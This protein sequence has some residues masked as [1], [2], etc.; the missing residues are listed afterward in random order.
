MMMGIGMSLYSH[1]EIVIAIDDAFTD[2]T[3]RI[4]EELLQNP[5]V[6]SNLAFY[7]KVA[8]LREFL[9]N[10]QREQVRRVNKPPISGVKKRPDLEYFGGLIV[11]EVESSENT[12]EIGRK[13]LRDY[14]NEFYKDVALY[15]IVTTGLYWEIYESARG[16]LRRIAVLKGDE[17]EYR[18]SLRSVIKSKPI[19]DYLYNLIKG[20]LLKSEAYRLPPLPNNIR[21]I[22][23]PVMSYVNDLIEL[24]HKYNVL[25][26]ALYQ[27]YK[28]ILLRAYG[29]LTD[30]EIDKL[31]ATHTLLQMIVNVIVAAA[32]G[33]LE[34]TIVKPIR[35]CSNEELEYDIAIPHLMWWREVSYIDKDFESR[36]EEIC[37]DIYYRALLFDWSSPIVEDVFSHLYED[38]VERTLRYKIG[39]Y[40]TPWWLIEFIIHHMKMRFNISFKDK[41]VFDPACGSG[42]FLV[43]AFYEKILEGED[44]DKA[45]L[46]VIGLDIL[47]LAATIARA[48]LIIAYRRATG[49][50]P[51][52]SPLVF[53]GD[54][55][56]HEI[57]LE[58]E[59]V[60]ELSSILNRLAIITW[61]ETW[62]NK[63]DKH[64]TWLF[65]ARLEYRMEQI[66]RELIE[67]G[68]EVSKTIASI[69]NKRV[70]RSADPI[71]SLVNSL[72][73]K[74]LRDNVIIQEIANLI[75]KYGNAIWVIPI[76]SDLF[77]R[78]LTRIKPDIV[79]TN[80]PWLKLSELPDSKWGK[81][82]RE[83][84]RK[85]IIDRYRNTIP[86]ISRVGMS[87]DI[88][89][90]F[91]N[92]IIR[93]L[94]KEGYVG[95]VLPAEQSYTPKSPHGTG[96]LLTYAVLSKYSVDGSAIYVGDAFK[97]G[98]HASVFILRVR[99]DG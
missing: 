62:L 36:V 39:E 18:K 57:G 86:G 43:R 42:R 54:F 99:K 32:F 67:S 80:P 13:Q 75:S 78:F 45:Y 61:E 4:S 58:A 22:F 2:I 28:E 77:V 47:P 27:S 25:E 24:M 98:R 46:E 59:V 7:N 44:P 10:G 88:S 70:L 83:Y 30:E 95:I 56:S 8:L 94:E 53:W 91:L 84:I 50:A 26:K 82:L 68:A 19:H 34:R 21:S 76:V 52:G 71:D 29:K 37:N 3:A 49:K 90:I 48:E 6:K 11:V 41:L 9:R 73:M 35:A 81:K 64:S 14:I 40:Y 66:F 89:A 69:I 60:K 12:L 17:K 33:K 23:Y 5:N 74:V 15:G 97:H 63:L 65:L 72:L 1:D 16:E 55:L 92:T 38:F 93:V 87:G 96:K 79:L 85:E 20:A 51:P 31:F